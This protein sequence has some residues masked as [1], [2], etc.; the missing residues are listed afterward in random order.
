MYKRAYDEY[1]KADNSKIMFFEPG[2]FPDE[3]GILGGFV[4]PLGFTEPPGG[5]GNKST[6]ILNDHTYCC[7]LSP[8]MCST[9]EPPADKAAECKAWHDKRVGT[10]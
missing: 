5:A 9:G 4:F 2:E 8:T 1:Y 10:R 7:Q 6:H 3:I